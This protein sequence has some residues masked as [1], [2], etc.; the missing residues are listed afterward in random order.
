MPSAHPELRFAMRGSTP[1]MIVSRCDGEESQST[2]ECPWSFGEPA[3]VSPSATRLFAEPCDESLE[4]ASMMLTPGEGLAG[5]DRGERGIL[6]A[7]LVCW[8][9]AAVSRDGAAGR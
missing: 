7:W 8:C 9:G 5:H 2:G 3:G 6:A 4:L 1:G